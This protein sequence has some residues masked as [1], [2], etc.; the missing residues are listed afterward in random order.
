[1]DLN[2]NLPGSSVLILFLPQRITQ[3]DIA[4]RI[5]VALRDA[6]PDMWSDLG[7]EIHDGIE[8]DH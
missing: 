1:M 5:A 2:T 7:N 3:E 8:R 4:P 6:Q